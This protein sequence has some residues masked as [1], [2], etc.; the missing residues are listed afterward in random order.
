MERV[1]GKGGAPRKEIRQSKAFKVYLTHDEFLL[2][3]SIAEE[4]GY[5][6][7]SGLIREKSLEFCNKGRISTANNP[8]IQAA[9]AYLGDI[10]FACS[11]LEQY[12]DEY[13]VPED[14]Y[15]ASVGLRIKIQNV[16]SFLTQ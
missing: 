8:M 14:V 5:P 16:E 6:T 13:N 15:E 9:S 3:K 11:V 2:I 12:V 10:A 4:L 7:I 1:K